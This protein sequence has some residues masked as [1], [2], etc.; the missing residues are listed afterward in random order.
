MEFRRSQVKDAYTVEAVYV[1]SSTGTKKYYM[2][3][4]GSGNFAPEKI[5]AADFNARFPSNVEIR[6]ND[7][8][9]NVAVIYNNNNGIHEGYFRLNTTNNTYVEIKIEGNNLWLSKTVNGKFVTGKLVATL[10]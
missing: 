2:I 7:T 4:D 1:P 5:D 10:D 9:P 8:Y 6:T 3:I